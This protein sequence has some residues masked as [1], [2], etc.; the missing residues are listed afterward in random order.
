MRDEVIRLVVGR[1]TWLIA[2]ITA[3]MA[4]ALLA[5]GHVEGDLIK[6][7]QVQNQVHALQQQVITL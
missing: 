2:L 4:I 3:M 1:V 7:D 6:Y 5:V